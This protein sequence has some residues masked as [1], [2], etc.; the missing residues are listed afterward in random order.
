MRIRK[1]SGDCFPDDWQ[2]FEFAEH[3]LDPVALSVARIVDV[4]VIRSIRHLQHHR[5]QHRTGVAPQRAKCR[6]SDRDASDDRDAQNMAGPVDQPLADG[7]L[8][9]RA[10]CCVHAAIRLVEHEIVPH[11][12]IIYRI[13]NR[14]RGR[15]LRPL[16]ARAKAGSTCSVSAYSGSRSSSA[17]ALRAGSCSAPPPGPRWTGSPTPR[18]SGRG[19][20]HSARGR[21]RTRSPQCQQCE[22]NVG[23]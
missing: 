12:R 23:K 8:F 9:A 22:A 2:V 21:H 6:S 1:Q 15:P 17:R 13:L 11:S 14:I 10:G 19:T 5:R 4:V 3:V 18:A 16:T 20:V 7:S